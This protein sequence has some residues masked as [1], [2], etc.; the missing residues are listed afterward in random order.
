MNDEYY[1]SNDYRDYL[2]HYGVKGMKWKNHRYVTE[3]IV[4]G[5]VR[6][7]VIRDRKG[8]PIGYAP[9]SPNR[10][11]VKKLKDKDSTSKNKK[12]KSGGVSKGAY[13]F[14]PIVDK[15]LAVTSNKMVQKNQV[16]LMPGE[17]LMTKSEPKK[18]D[19][20]TLSKP[21]SSLVLKMSAKT[22]YKKVSSV[23]N[24][25]GASPA[26]RGHLS[27]L[28]DR[29]NESRSKAR[30]SSDKKKSKKTQSTNRRRKK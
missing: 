8:R 12:S 2:S 9:A 22:T 19:E 4:R 20:K 27:S 14:K 15:S 28:V 26:I 5:G 21:A 17:S 7:R 25:L 6:M 30:N 24:N 3:E 1:G 23:L 16:N 18:L 29:F 10:R 11:V 13:E